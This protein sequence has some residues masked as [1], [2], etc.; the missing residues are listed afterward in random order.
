MYSYY[1]STSSYTHRICRRENFRESHTVEYL[2]HAYAR[3][4]ASSEER[5]FFWRWTAGVPSRACYRSMWVRR[6]EATIRRMMLYC[7]IIMYYTELE[8]Q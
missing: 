4:H 3:A 6:S 1:F 7:I 5:S 8:S 2:E